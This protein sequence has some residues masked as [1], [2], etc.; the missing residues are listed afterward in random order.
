[1]K[2]CGTAH[3]Q[4]DS[5]LCIVSPKQEVKTQKIEPLI[6]SVYKAGPP[7]CDT[8]VKQNQNMSH[9]LQLQLQLQGPLW[10]N[11][12]I[13]IP[14]QEGWDWAGPADVWNLH[15]YVMMF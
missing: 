10:D 11:F 4:R 1:M 3:W 13:L 9:Q 14:T 7:V 2:L 6:S 15:N 12:Y 5:S 8:R